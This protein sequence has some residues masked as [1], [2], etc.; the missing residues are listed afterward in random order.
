MMWEEDDN[1]LEID[2][3]CLETHRDENRSLDRHLCAV[4]LLVVISAEGGTG[5]L[6]RARS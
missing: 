5:S 6:D 4:L 3:R 2:S 1:D